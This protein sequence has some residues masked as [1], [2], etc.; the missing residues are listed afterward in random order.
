[1][2]EVDD[3][4]GIALFDGLTPDQLAMLSQLLHRRAVPGGTTLM[5]AE[6]PGEVAY[7]I[8]SGTVKVYVDQP[9]GAEVILELHGPGQLVG[10]MSLLDDVERSASVVALERCNLLWIDRTAFAT[11]LRTMPALAGNV[12]RLLSRRLRLADAR[13]QALSTLDLYARVARQLLALADVRGVPAAGGAVLIPLRLTQSDLAALVGASRVRVN[14]VM[15]A[16][17][18]LGYLTVDGDHRMTILDRA[19]L[20]RRFAPPS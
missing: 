2:L 12:T 8:L 6:E 17:K 10:E 15:V 9:D 19:A 1:M 4:R 20:A 7:L 11:C 18:R 16:Y 5:L 13:I 14:E 3:L